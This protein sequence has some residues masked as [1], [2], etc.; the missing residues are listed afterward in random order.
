LIPI[1]VGWLP[2]PSQTRVFGTTVPRIL[3]GW[4]EVTTNIRW[5]Y[6]QCVITANRFIY[7]NSRRI[8]AAQRRTDTVMDIPERKL[9]SIGIKANPKDFY[10]NRFLQ[11][12]E[13]SGFVKELYGAK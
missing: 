5:Q 4:Q 7:S 3:A 6:P 9:D 8:S 13:S 10:D 11:E 1:L 2:V 12:L